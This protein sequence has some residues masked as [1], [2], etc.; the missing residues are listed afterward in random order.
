MVLMNMARVAVNMPHTFH[1]MVLGNIP[2]SCT[3]DYFRY[4][5][6]TH[7]IRGNHLSRA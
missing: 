5:I 4:G 7:V 1:K 2:F 6:C 3:T